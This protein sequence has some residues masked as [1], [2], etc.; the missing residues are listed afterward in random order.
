MYL[1]TSVLWWSFKKTDQTLGIMLCLSF[2]LDPCMM[3]HD[4]TKE[5]TRSRCSAE[6][7]PVIWGFADLSDTLMSPL[8]LS[9]W[10]PPNR[11]QT[12]SDHNA[13]RTPEECTPCSSDIITKRRDGEW[14]EEKKEGRRERLVYFHHSVPAARS[15]FTKCINHF[16]HRP[17][18]PPIWGF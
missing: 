16:I 14:E 1:L 4:E 6:N 17:S 10:L 8:I 13:T 5:Q 11:N 18:S 9:E 12:R 3:L 7:N 2:H 15:Q